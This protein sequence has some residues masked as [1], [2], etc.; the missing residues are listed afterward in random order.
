MDEIICLMRLFPDA[1]LYATSYTRVWSDGKRQDAQMPRSIKKNKPQIVEQLFLTFS[2]SSIFSISSSACVRRQ[3][4]VGQNIY[5]PLGESVGEDQDVIFRLAEKGAI[6]FSPRFLVE[7][8]Q[9]VS[10]SLYSVLPDYLPPCYPRLAERMESS[11]FPVNQRKGAARLLSVGYLN[12]AREKIQHGKRKRA[13]RLLF[14][15]RA[16]FHWTYWIRTLVRFCLPVSV[17]R[18]GWMRRI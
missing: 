18:F 12:V 13:M 4:M 16:F 6:A 2:R 8:T 15:P 3:A 7:Y 11:S 1:I 14:H 17:F 5:F 10:N 9:G